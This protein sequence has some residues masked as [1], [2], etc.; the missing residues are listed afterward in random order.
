MSTV[1]LAKNPSQTKVIK[2]STIQQ[3]ANDFDFGYLC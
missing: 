3:S 2:W 1:I